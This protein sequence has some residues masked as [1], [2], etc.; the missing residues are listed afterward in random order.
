MLLSPDPGPSL[1]LRPAS[2]HLSQAD[3]EEPVAAPVV[4]EIKPHLPNPREG[5]HVFGV[6]HIF[7]SFNDTFV[8]RIASSA[9]VPGVPIRFFHRQTLNATR[10]LSTIG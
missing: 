10:N 8:V 9:A 7:A 5:E 2:I 3:T 6:A 1:T 4:E